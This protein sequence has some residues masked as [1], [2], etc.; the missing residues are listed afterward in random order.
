LDDVGE[1][2]DRERNHAGTVAKT[3]GF[4]SAGV[5]MNKPRSF[6]RCRVGACA[7]LTHE[8]AA[9]GDPTI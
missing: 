8:V 9:S 1:I 6:S 4:A 5:G 3:G 7:D 2:E